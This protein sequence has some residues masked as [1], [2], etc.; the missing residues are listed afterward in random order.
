MTLSKEK[1][2]EKR[3]GSKDRDDKVRRSSSHEDA[4]E[5]RIAHEAEKPRDEVAPVPCK[6]ISHGDDKDPRDSH[7]ESKT[8]KLERT[9]STGLK[10][11]LF[12]KVRSCPTT[13]FTL[14]FYFRFVSI[15][16]PG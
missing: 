12:N 8:D 5:K 2:R 3:A 6:R 10:A 11:A 7:K 1:S 9:K 4:R 13:T 14:S 15:P 16:V